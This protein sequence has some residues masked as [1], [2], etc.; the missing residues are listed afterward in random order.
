MQ[1]FPAQPPA[2]YSKHKEQRSSSSAQVNS[3]RARDCRELRAARVLE[4]DRILFVCVFCLTSYSI[5]DSKH[6]PR[7]P[8][9]HAAP[10]PCRPYSS[11]MRGVLPSSPL[12][13]RPNERNCIVQAGIETCCSAWT[14]RKRIGGAVWRSDEY[15]L[16][17]HTRFGGQ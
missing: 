13:P 1:F 8:E 4:R 9:A 5:V 14:R 3:T 10:P 7:V 11:V 6:K 2:S 15:S 12:P 16:D 17:Q